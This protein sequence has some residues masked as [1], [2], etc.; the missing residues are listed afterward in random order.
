MRQVGN[1]ILQ[2]RKRRLR[3]LQSFPQD[4]S[5]T[6]SHPHVHL[7]M[8]EPKL[9]AALEKARSQACLRRE[10]TASSSTLSLLCSR[11][12][13]QVTAPEAHFLCPPPLSSTVSSSPVPALTPQPG[14]PTL[15]SALHTPLT[16][17]D[18]VPRRG[19]VLLHALVRVAPSFSN[20]CSFLPTYC[21]HPLI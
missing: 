1:P 19:R 21:S 10:R 4:H 2:L 13:G 16:P 11:T 7:Q 20:A 17:V 9:P 15:V 12:R 14:I 3:E 5:R 8:L 18:S 6:G